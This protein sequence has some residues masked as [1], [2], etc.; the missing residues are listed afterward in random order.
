MLSAVGW[1]VLAYFFIIF[2]VAVGAVLLLIKVYNDRVKDKE[3]EKYKN[4]KK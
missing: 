1:F 3:E 2:A 4:I